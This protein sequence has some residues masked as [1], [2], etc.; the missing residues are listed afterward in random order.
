VPA[1][2][3]IEYYTTD[4]STKTLH[5]RLKTTVHTDGGHFEDCVV[6]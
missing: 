1:W 2:H 6:D 5:V 4:A 3:R